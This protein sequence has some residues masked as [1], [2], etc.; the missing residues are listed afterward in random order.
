MPKSL[1]K[2]I[3]ISYHQ[4]FPKTR[5]VFGLVLGKSPSSNFKRRRERYNEKALKKQ[6]KARFSLAVQ[7]YVHAIRAREGQ[8]S[9]HTYEQQTAIRLCSRD[10]R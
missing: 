1:V 10:S 7:S 5:T 2:N 3:N 8:S 6:Q 9:G 4:G